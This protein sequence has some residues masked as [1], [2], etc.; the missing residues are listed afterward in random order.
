MRERKTKKKRVMEREKR[1][2]AGRQAGTGP[3]QAGR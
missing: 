2:K 1:E 3:T